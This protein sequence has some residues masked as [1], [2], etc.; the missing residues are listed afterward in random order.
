VLHEGLRAALCPSP[1]LSALVQAC[2]DGPAPLRDSPAR[3]KPQME[4]IEQLL[5]EWILG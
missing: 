4:V 1:G 5:H 3:R 2:R